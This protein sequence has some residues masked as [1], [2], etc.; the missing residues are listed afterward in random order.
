QATASATQTVS[1]Q[2]LEPV[3][4][5]VA[6]PLVVNA[7][8]ADNAI[9]CTGG[10]VAADGLVSIDSQET[11]EFSNKTTLTINALAGNDTINLNNPNTPTGLTSITVNGND[12]TASDTVI[13]NGTAAA[14]TINFAPTSANAATVT[15]AGPVAI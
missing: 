1:F 14:D 11:I 10:S 9:N 13:L 12:P 15:G 8:N 3:I 4:D 7:T 6:G 5:L 2:N